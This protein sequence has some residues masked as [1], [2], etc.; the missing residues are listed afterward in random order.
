MAERTYMVVDGRRDHSF[1]VPRP[2]LSVSL[3]T[4]NACNGCHTKND[5][6]WAA[7]IIA[8]WFRSPDGFTVTT[9]HYDFNYYGLPGGTYNQQ[10]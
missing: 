10:G 6:S 9:L 1:R 3:G 5:A 8:K 4:P 2:D 7:D